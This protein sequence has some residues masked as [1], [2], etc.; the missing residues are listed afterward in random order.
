[1]VKI[2]RK[3]DLL[4]SRQNAIDI[5]DIKLY[6]KLSLEYK[7]N[8]YITP[9]TSIKNSADINKIEA[10]Q[11]EGNSKLNNPLKEK[12]TSSFLPPSMR[13]IS[14]YTKEFICNCRR[15]QCRKNYCE[16]RKN[17][18]MCDPKKCSCEECSNQF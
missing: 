3:I 11:D 14:P 10:N 6:H 4:V 17:K 2:K 16:C 13:I 15:N 18:E 1:M 8:F 12:V 5:R 7:H 9:S